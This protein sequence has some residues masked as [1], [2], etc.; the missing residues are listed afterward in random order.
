MDLKKG[1]LINDRYLVEEL[2][3]EGGMGSVYKV[4]DFVENRISALKLIKEKI[5]SNKAID[6]FKNEFKLVINLEH[7]N[8]IEVY[9]FDIYKK[10]DTYFITM[11]YIEGENLN[12]SFYDMSNKNKYDIL[13]Q[14]SRGLNYIHSR[15]IVHFDIKPDNI[16]LVRNE[17]KDSYQVK[18]MDFGL[19]SLLE[20]FTGKVRG[21]L[22][23]I[24]PEVMLKKEVDYRADL[25]SLGM[26]I[27]HLFS[28]KLPF[29]EYT[30]IKAIVRAKLDEAFISEDEFKYLDNEF[31]KNLIIDLCRAKKEDRILNAQQLMNYLETALEID[32]KSE[33]D[34]KV[35]DSFNDSYYF[36]KH[37]FI[38]KIQDDYLN[39][40]LRG[41]K[42]SG[43]LNLIVGE[44]GSGKTQFLKNFNIKA[45]LNRVPILFLSIEDEKETT[46]NIFFRKIIFGLLAYLEDDR[47]KSDVIFNKAIKLID[48]NTGAF[49]QEDT[50]I[51]N[52]KEV[53]RL[54][55]TNLSKNLSPIILID[56]IFNFKEK[57]NSLFLYLL[58]LIVKSPVFL[59][60]SI[61]DEKYNRKR[62]KDYE[63]IFYL[64]PSEKFIIRNLNKDEVT[65]YISALLNISADRIDPNLMETILLESSG[66]ISLIKNQIQFL[67]ENNFLFLEKDFYK[68]NYFSNEKYEVDV[69]DI[70]SD[71]LLA[72]N[73]L[74]REILIFINEGLCLGNEQELKAVFDIDIEEVKLVLDKLIKLNLISY[75]VTENNTN[76]NRGN[77]SLKNRSMTLLIKKIFDDNYL[78]GFFTSLSNYFSRVNKTDKE[79]VRFTY[80]FI[81]STADLKKKI[82]A[83]EKAIT[84]CRKNFKEIPLKE[85]LEH[86]INHFDVPNEKKIEVLK[87]LYMVLIWDKK[88]DEAIIYYNEILKLLS[89]SDIK[90]GDEIS[91]I[92]A[93]V[94]SDSAYFNSKLISTEDRVGYLKKGIIFYS[95]NLEKY[96]NSFIQNTHKVIQIYLRSGAIEKCPR[97][98]EEM[99]DIYSEKLNDS[100]IGRLKAIEWF[101]NYASVIK[102][103]EI[104]EKLVGIF[105]SL[106]ADN[107]IPGEEETAIVITL[108]NQIVLEKTHFPLK[109]AEL[110][111]ELSDKKADKT[112]DIALYYIYAKFLEKYGKLEKSITIYNKLE[113]FIEDYKGMYGILSVTIDKIDTLNNMKE[114]KKLI[115]LNFEKAYS[116][117]NRINDNTSLFRLYT[118]KINY[119]ISKGEFR[120]VDLNIKFALKHIAF[121]D[122]YRIIQNYIV[123]AFFYFYTLKDSESF[124]ELVNKVNTVIQSKEGNLESCFKEDVALFKALFTLANEENVDYILNL[125]TETDNNKL[126]YILLIK[127]LNNSWGT[128]R[129]IKSEFVLRLIPKLIV[130]FNREPIIQ[131]YLRSILYLLN[132]E[133]KN[134]YNEVFKLVKGNFNS[135]FIFDC[136]YPILTSLLYFKNISLYKNALYYEEKIEKL[137]HKLQTQLAYEK[138]YNFINKYNIY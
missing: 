72:L 106:E 16:I 25:Y 21:T 103:S 96:G 104:Y 129:T 24:A 118:S 22:S 110:Y 125:I 12:R 60:V 66:N 49:V 89:T 44:V 77:L 119:L 14:I 34:K 81:R 64:F 20:E 26:V 18:I 11:E 27:Y 83:L 111:I 1:T 137:I 62:I 105:Q 134:S 95:H 73:K 138:R 51:Y 54:V 41:E 90:E 84:Y 57:D 23:Y 123:V 80:C 56:N 32:V 131:S 19:A 93:A 58:H 109:T 88:Q 59:V 45:Q 102:K 98:I 94:Y 61:N 122:S 33:D 100:L 107:I 28:N 135:G 48:K 46:L 17:K 63:E 36:D 8:I 132:E 101:F 74:E 29:E 68:Y 50:L 115:E 69:K 65:E 7:R 113:E 136:Y 121:V 91:S 87:E 112:G 97:F 4:K 40:C 99:I 70:Y 53:L 75:T 78:L 47:D 86:Y 2:L 6:R 82:K 114:D 108:M 130:T 133:Y 3:G 85:F 37:D 67:I 126:K 71:R 117:A 127:Y 52:I 5:F 55:F 120:E 13:M 128:Y 124:Y 92:L 79:T 38:R 116:I 43:K 42:K 9:D 76:T 39:F 31:L 10:I 35:N 30:S 15:H